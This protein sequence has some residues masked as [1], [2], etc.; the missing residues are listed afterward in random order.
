MQNQVELHRGCP[1]EVFSAQGEPRALF[2]FLIQFLF[3]NWSI[4][5]VQITLQVILC[6]T[7]YNI[8]LQVMLQVYSI[9]M[10]NF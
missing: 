2:F 7:I 5:D 8:I 4:F 1:Q 6:N 10:Q 3:S 9:V